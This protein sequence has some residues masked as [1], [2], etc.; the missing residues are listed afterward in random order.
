MFIVYTVYRRKS[1]LTVMSMLNKLLEVNSQTINNTREA[2]NSPNAIVALRKQTFLVMFQYEERKSTTFQEL[3]N[4]SI[5]NDTSSSYD[6][7]NTLLLSESRE[8]FDKYK[9]YSAQS[10][11]STYNSTKTIN[12][13]GAWIESNS[14]PIHNR[15]REDFGDVDVSLN[16]EN[17]LSMNQGYF[18][19]DIN[20]QHIVPYV[21]TP[22]DQ[23]ED[24]TSNGPGNDLQRNSLSHIGS[25][26]ITKRKHV[27]EMDIVRISD[28]GNEDMLMDSPVLACGD[29]RRRIGVSS[30]RSHVVGRRERN[31]FVATSVDSLEGIPHAPT[32]SDSNDE[33]DV[34]NDGF[35]T[36]PQ[37]KAAKEYNYF[38]EKQGAV[39]AHRNGDDLTAE[40]VS[41]V[42]NRNDKSENGDEDD[43]NAKSRVRVD[44]H[45]EEDEENESAVIVTNVNRSIYFESNLESAVAN[46]QDMTANKDF[47]YD[48]MKEVIEKDSVQESD[49]Q[50][51]MD[52]P[53]DITGENDD[54]KDQSL[55]MEVLPANVSRNRRNNNN[56][57]NRG[58]KTNI[59][60]KD[61]F[62]IVQVGNS[63]FDSTPLV[64]KILTQDI[65]SNAQTTQTGGDVVL[66]RQ[67][68]L[69]LTQQII[70]MQHT[71]T[72]L[73]SDVL[74]WQTKYDDVKVDNTELLTK[75][76][77]LNKVK[78][79]NES[80][81]ATFKDMLMTSTSRNK[82]LE[83]KCIEL[84][85]ERDQTN[86]EIT[87]KNTLLQDSYQKLTEISKY[88]ND[89]KLQNGQ[90]GEKVAIMDAKCSS[91]EHNV[92]ELT[93]EKQSLKE[94]QT[95]IVIENDNLK[96]ALQKQTVNN[97]DTQARLSKLQQDHLMVVEQK[98]SMSSSY[99]ESIKKEDALKRELDLKTNELRQM[100][101]RYAQDMSVQKKTYDS[102]VHDVKEEK[103]QAEKE[104]AGK[105]FQLEK[106]NSEKILRLEKEHSEKVSRLE[107]EHS[108]A[109]HALQIQY[110]EL[111]QRYAVVETDLAKHKDLILYINKLSA[112]RACQ[113]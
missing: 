107:K 6:I 38:N 113:V 75:V 19:Y 25:F 98:N 99:E 83:M 84:Q 91:F 101:E 32:D 61:H 74:K 95:Q 65:S 36:Q 100:M 51:D 89:L 104:H 26:D 52:L 97:E 55:S 57:S 35:D 87:Q 2:T 102:Y 10:Y 37:S 30:S 105:V 11:N 7:E 71:I 28:D 88:C 45:V 44:S 9:Q 76:N 62:S 81:I 33:N 85:Y 31:C 80:N 54:E 70:Q 56:N 40:N 93:L 73:N 8:L 43:E 16:H 77:N 29:N 58:I 48:Q 66:L 86:K 92:M 108:V 39:D 90:Q 79:T 12:S 103:E 41:Y 18:I 60:Q 72:N 24:D 4:T 46:T 42:H 20:T 82:E 94:L 53:V 14:T 5:V 1:I 47:T 21:N 59:S 96:F 49:S 63:A 3:L 23:E 22:I 15:L 27:H 106:E 64:N 34:E 111:L 109:L 13:G 78:I 68:N 50:H 67:H 112:E 17:S 69:T 110:D